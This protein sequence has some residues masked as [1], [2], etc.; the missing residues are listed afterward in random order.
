MSD[1]ENSSLV[2]S[3]MTLR[4]MVGYL[5]I[6]LPVLVV[7]G[8]EL[9]PA[10][11]IRDSVS[12]YYYSS[13]RDLFVGSLCMVGVFLYS[14]RGYDWVDDFLTSL[15]GLLALGV[16]LFPTRSEEKVP[17]AVGIFQLNDFVSGFIHYTCAVLLFV[18]L[19][20][21]S[22]FLFTKT[23]DP[24]AMTKQ[25]KAR[26]HFYRICGGIMFAA[27]L[28]CGVFCLPVLK[29]AAP[30]HLI[31]GVETSCLWAF[32]ISWLIKGEALLGDEGDTVKSCGSRLIR[33]RPF[34]A[35]PACLSCATS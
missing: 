9:I 14:Y 31:L 7:I 32:G 25:K 12:A 19:A 30:P 33:R 28:V 1:P 5:G 22:T 6:L 3:Y 2:I 17:V 21:I 11:E 29:N 35:D 13:M 4:K 18:L 16:A 23:A 8:G 15:S 24:Q 26:N 34:R 27:M 20:S 10:G